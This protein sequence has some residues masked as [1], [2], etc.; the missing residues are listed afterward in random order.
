MRM[1]RV[2][3]NGQFEILWS[4][5]TPRRPVPYPPTRPR[6]AWETFLQGLYKGWGDNWEAPQP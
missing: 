6:A 4:S 2:V 1:G 3:E 5:E